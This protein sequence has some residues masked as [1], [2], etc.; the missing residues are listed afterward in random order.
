MGKKYSPASII[1]LCLLGLRLGSHLQPLL[2][3][4]SF[5]AIVAFVLYLI[6]FVGV[7]KRKRWASMMSGII[8]LLD[9]L[10]TL[11]YVGGAN[12]VGAAVMDGALVILSYL[13]YRNLTTKDKSETAGES[14]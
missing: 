5:G 14:T 1:L 11:F 4:Q 3:S 6:P 12:M 8:G 7:L 2:V 10:M 9:F 13:D